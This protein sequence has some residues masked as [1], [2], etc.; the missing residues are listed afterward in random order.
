MATTYTIRTET[1]AVRNS[2]SHGD[3]KQSTSYTVVDQDG[4]SWGST[5][6][7]KTAQERRGYSG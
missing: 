7:L 4:E 5:G 3:F 6:D 2:L 1:R